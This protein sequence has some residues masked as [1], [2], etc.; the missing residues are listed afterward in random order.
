MVNAESHR[1]R[2]LRYVVVTTSPFLPVSGYSTPI[3]YSQNLHIFNLISLYLVWFSAFPY[4]FHSGSHYFDI[5]SLVILSIYSYHLNLREG[6]NFTMF[7]LVIYPAFHF[8]LILQPFPPSSSSSSS[9]SSSFLLILILILH[10]L[11]L[12]FYGP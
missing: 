5:T 3:Y 12:L 10:H 11:L 8:I 6:I 4:Y 2:K 1:Q 9:S 7:P